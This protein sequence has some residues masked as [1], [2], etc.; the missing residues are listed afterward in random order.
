MKKYRLITIL[1]VVAVATFT[2]N[3]CTND[4]N[5]TPLDKSVTTSN[6]T[7]TKSS[8]PYVEFLAKLYAGLATGGIQGGDA[9]VD[10][11]GY[12]GGSQAGYLR[13]LW[14]LQEL[15]TDEAMC[16]WND[17]TI[18][19]FHLFTWTA[20]D[21]FLEAFYE[22][23][24]YQISVSTAFLQQTTAAQLTSRG[25]SKTLSDSITQF[26]AEA[27]FIRALAYFNVLD[28]YRNGPLVNDDS[29]LGTATP[30]PYGTSQQIFSFIESELTA[31]Q[32][33]LIA[34]SVG[35]S[36][37]A[38]G[39]A[40]KAA[41]WALLSRLYLNANTYLGTS[42]PTYYTKCITN[43]NN[44]ISA[45]YQLEPVYQ[46][47]FVSDNYKSKEMIFPIV[48][49]GTQ[50]TSWGGMMF[51]MSSMVNSDNQALIASPGAWG[52]NRA[53]QEFV[54][55]FNPPTG[56]GYSITD[57][58]RYTML[59]T[60]FAHPSI[61]DNSQYKQGTPLLKYSE[62]NSAGVAPNPAPSFPDT[63]FP[64]FRLGEI[65]LNYAEAVLRG[66]TGGTTTQALAYVNALRDRAFP[67]GNGEITSTQL[68]L[69][70][71]LEERAREMFSEAIRRTDLV[72]FGKL[73]DANYLW[74]WKAGVKAGQGAPVFRN[75][76]PL[77]NADLNA[78]PNLK[79][80]TGY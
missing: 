23:L 15:P 47:M 60:G 41:A 38:Y 8:G 51:L 53:T 69:P 28:M 31:C 26:R 68:T 75:Y 64:L 11:T 13:P 10:I 2:F 70:F 9:Q 67:L 49:D 6:V 61:D 35:F 42:D 59:Y 22:R 66:G 57:D 37:T 63:D 43:C 56:A 73:T 72:R 32:T 34:P 78:N 1:A 48:F 71:M 5:V 39:H 3:S 4:L 52:G 58:S 36:A 62:K 79:Q 17:Q 65:Y 14:N 19:N 50:L 21:I 29:P 7:F 33:D 40:S 74:Q 80:N 12:D 77:P 44:I 25:V 20:S 24:Y 16:C 30:P 45:G 55:R 46:N 27:R 54:A 76:Y 18:Q